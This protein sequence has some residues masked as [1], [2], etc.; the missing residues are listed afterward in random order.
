MCGAYPKCVDAS[1]VQRLSCSRM[2]EGDAATAPTEVESPVTDIPR[3][4]GAEL[5]ARG[6]RRTVLASLMTAHG[7]VVYAFCVRI[8][9]DRGLAEDVLQQVFLEV[10]RD[11]DRFQGRSTVRSWLLGIAAHRCHDAIKARRRRD[12][13]LYSDDQAITNSVDPTAG[14]GD[15]LERARLAAAL[16]DCLASLSADSR[17]AVLLRFQAGM[18]YEEMAASLTAKSDTLHARVTRALPV[19]RRCLEGKG[20]DGE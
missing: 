17:T 9:R 20:W 5:L 14:P 18:S 3:I 10:H 8:L 19:L 1:L 6:D 15:R 11:L 12:A 4:S 7:D 2:S 13:R 16:E